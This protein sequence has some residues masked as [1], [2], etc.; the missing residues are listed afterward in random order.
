MLI[1]L[2]GKNCTQQIE[3]AIWSQFVEP[4]ILPAPVN[5]VR[6]SHP[7]HSDVLQ[8]RYPLAMVQKWIRF[9]WSR[10]LNG[11]SQHF[12]MIFLTG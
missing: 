2:T 10:W 4:R 9:A 8:D 6:T 5:L 12:L 7:D 3:I 11:A 1:D